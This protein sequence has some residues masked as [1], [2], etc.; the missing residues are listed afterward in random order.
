M[1][2]VSRFLFKSA[3]KSSSV[4]NY[5]RIN[6]MS[7]QKFN[8]GAKV[9]GGSK[10]DKDVDKSKKS[11]SGGGATASDSERKE[12]A[13]ST[14]KIK[15]GQTEAAKPAE[16]PK[17]EVKKEAAKHAETPKVEKKPETSSGPAV[18]VIETVLNHRV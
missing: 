4:L 3:L 16:V 18:K 5:V 15:Q 1:F 13:S 11:V 9:S 14:M 6:P 8:F 12:S 10:S 17:T 2:S 7:I